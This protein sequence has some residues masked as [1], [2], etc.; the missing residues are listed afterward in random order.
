VGFRNS[1]SR[2][3][4][5]SCWSVFPRRTRLSI[6]DLLRNDSAAADRAESAR[7]DFGPADLVL[8]RARETQLGRIEEEDVSKRAHVAKGA[9]QAGGN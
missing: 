9:V 1:V 8:A 7:V 3:R 2:R 5:D 6:V 4:L